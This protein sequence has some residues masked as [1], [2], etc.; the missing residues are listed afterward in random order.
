MSRLSAGTG[1]FSLRGDAA[2]QTLIDAITGFADGIEVENFSF[3]PAR[4]GIPERKPLEGPTNA[5]LKVTSK[6]VA[7]CDITLFS[8]DRSEQVELPAEIYSPGM[9]GLP[10]ELRRMRIHTSVFDMAVSPFSDDDKAD[11]DVKISF[12]FDT[13]YS[14]SHLC[15][16]AT[17][18]GWLQKGAIE[19]EM[20]YD[21][22]RGLEGQL[23]ATIPTGAPSWSA[24]AFVLKRLRDFVP[25]SQQPKQLLFRVSDFAE[26]KQLLQGA[27]MLGAENATL[28]MTMAEPINHPG[29]VN[30][31][32]MPVYFDVGPA[33][34]FGICKYKIEK[35][36]IDANRL[37]IILTDGTLL[38]RAV[39]R[40]SVA[41]N[42]DF[43]N[44]EIAAAEQRYSI[45]SSGVLFHRPAPPSIGTADN[46]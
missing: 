41:D 17:I 12:D 23:S 15:D 1:K 45:G 35:F 40:G 14:L 38:S 42:T 21:G 5:K 32:I 31:Y 4:F 6:P 2:V 30:R 36:E 16:T 7:I 10:K 25:I 28:R 43:I 9:P 26:M 33:T 24:L 18:F 8:P 27:Q 13:A 19:F 22:R 3:T 37:K 20:W 39:L 29:D 11:G 44:A 46:P 34:Y